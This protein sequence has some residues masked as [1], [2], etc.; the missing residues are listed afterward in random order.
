MSYKV[1][2]DVFEG[3]FDLLVYL[4]ERSKMSIYD[5]E[6]SKIT[7]QYLE[8]VK[9]LQEDR[10]IELA[11][12]F[13]VLAAELIKIKSR[14]LLP[15]E[16]V[17]NEQ[18]EEEVVDPRKELVQKILEYKAFKEMSAFLA[19]QQE[20]TSHI[21]EKPAED[22]EAYTGEPEE[23]IKGSMEEFANAF[24]AFILKKQRIEAVHRIYERIERQKMSMEK[25]IREVI[26]QLEQRESMMFSE[27]IGK[28]N[29]NFNKVVTFTSILELLKQKTITADQEK[30]FGDI[31]IKKASNFENVNIEEAV[32][33][34]D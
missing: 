24:M 34:N 27:L 8:Y 4:I 6:I 9:A 20:I 29:T 5:I 12:E 17:I 11:Q 19:D 2:L 21:H 31:T 13:M 25:R 3:P 14:M 16:T 1:K 26:T 23:I 22:I 32:A 15:I 7:S 28:E 10:D 30:Q 18:G 33:G